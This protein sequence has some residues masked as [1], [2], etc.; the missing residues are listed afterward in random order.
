M[1]YLHASTMAFVTLVLIQIVNAFNAR[2]AKHSVFV[3]KQNYY[4]WGAAFISTGMIVLMIN[5]EWLRNKIEI[6]Q[7][8]PKDW[9]IVILTSFSVLVFE[10]VRKLISK[11]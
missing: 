7:L 6:V 9:L 2:S 8:S 1:L 10:E 11:K 3:L 5:L 4:L